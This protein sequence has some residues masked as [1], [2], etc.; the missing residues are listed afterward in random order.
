MLTPT[1]K[2]IGFVALWYRQLLGTV[3]TLLVVKTPHNALAVVDRSFSSSALQRDGDDRHD[4][5]PTTRL[6]LSAFSGHASSTVAQ[7]TLRAVHLSCPRFYYYAA[8]LAGIEALKLK[9]SK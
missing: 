7:Q 4:R 1:I 6:R 9:T 3:D 8:K 5:P 2:C